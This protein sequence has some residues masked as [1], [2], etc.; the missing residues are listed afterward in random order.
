MRLKRSPGSRANASED[1]GCRAQLVVQYHEFS[2]RGRVGRGLLVGTRSPMVGCRPLRTCV[3][4]NVNNV[5]LKDVVISPFPQNV[6]PRIFS[7][8]NAEQMFMT[9]LKYQKPY[10]A[11]TVLS[12][13][14]ATSFE[15]FSADKVPHS[16]NE[17]SGM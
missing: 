1:R 11:Q 8:P 15:G 7:D 4:I 13:A 9:H 5:K 2:E 12:N 10:L 16:A 14:L 6:L 3:Q 17:G